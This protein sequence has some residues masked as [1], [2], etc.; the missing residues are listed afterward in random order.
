[1]KRKLYLF[2]AA[3]LFCKIIFAQH[4]PVLSNAAENSGTDANIGV[5]NYRCD[6]AIDPS[7]SKNIS[8]TV[9][10]YFKTAAANVS[11]ITFYLNNLL[12]GSPV[13]KYS[14]NNF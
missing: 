10:T 13:T 1:M 2:T 11:V 8:G 9:T 12:F 6:W 3:L 7:T 14:H 4:S 5:V